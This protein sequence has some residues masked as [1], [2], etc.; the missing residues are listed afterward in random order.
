[1]CE[2]KIN[3]QSNKNSLFLKGVSEETLKSI[4]KNFFAAVGVEVLENKA[5]TTTTTKHTAVKPSEVNIDK[6]N[7][8][9]SRPKQLPLIDAIRS[10]FPISDLATV[11]T[12]ED[13]SHWETG[14]KIKEGVETYRTR[15]ECSCGNKGK[16][17]VPKEDE[18]VICHNCGEPLEKVP[19]TEAGFPGRDG[20]GNFFI[21]N[22]IWTSLK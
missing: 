20:F 14:I 3:V 15:Y 6:T 9:V 19:A 10:S 16:R 7:V 17:Y 21:A 5:V 8:V 1:M 2:I 11:K 4:T 13:T 12:E 22:E 18:Y